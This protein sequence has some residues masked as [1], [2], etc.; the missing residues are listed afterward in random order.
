MPSNGERVESHPDSTRPNPRRRKLTGR[1]SRPFGMH[2][3]AWAMVHLQGR[4]P[5]W[6]TEG[7][8][9][10]LVGNS[11][12]CSWTCVHVASSELPQR[13]AGFAHPNPARCSREQPPRQPPHIVQVTPSATVAHRSLYDFS[14]T[15]MPRLVRQWLCRGVGDRLDPTGCEM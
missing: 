12:L 9:E 5:A 6:R 15:T 11:C 8:V 7:T 4:T 14:E 1:R 10:L 3:G 2:L 13:S